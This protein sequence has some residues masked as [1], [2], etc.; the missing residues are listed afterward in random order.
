MVVVHRVDAQEHEDDRLRAARQHLH[1]VLDRRVRLGRDVALHVVL[2]RDAAEC[3]PAPVS[4]SLHHHQLVYRVFLNYVQLVGRPDCSNA[5]IGRSFLLESSRNP[6][7]GILLLGQS[8]WSIN[9]Q[10]S[11]RDQSGTNQV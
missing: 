4:I 1:S 8:C 3:D 11:G 6:M 2:H 5:L 10:R 9:V 7:T